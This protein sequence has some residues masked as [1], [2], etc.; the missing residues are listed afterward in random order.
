MATHF[1]TSTCT[2]SLGSQMI[3]MWAGPSILAAPP[4]LDPRRIST[5]SPKAYAALPD[6]RNGD[7]SAAFDWDELSPM[8]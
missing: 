2:Y 6:K 1:R 4:S 7:S 3:R 8:S 5:F